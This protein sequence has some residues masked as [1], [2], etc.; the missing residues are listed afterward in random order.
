[1]RMSSR[2]VPLETSYV[3]WNNGELSRK[4]T[5]DHCVK[6]SGSECPKYHTRL[7]QCMFAL[8]VT[9]SAQN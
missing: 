2:E 5:L 1:L 4:W 9:L 6:P 7:N 3:L 8:S